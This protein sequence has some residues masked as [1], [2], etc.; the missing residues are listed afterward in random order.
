M[1]VLQQCGAIFIHGGKAEI[2]VLQR[3]GILPPVEIISFIAKSNLLHIQEACKC[4]QQARRH[5]HTFLL[6]NAAKNPY[7][8]LSAQYNACT[9]AQKA[10]IGV[11]SKQIR[12]LPRGICRQKDN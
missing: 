11:S 2:K 6:I 5:E 9:F 7:H 1:Y 8:G 4:R 3:H 12:T 10:L